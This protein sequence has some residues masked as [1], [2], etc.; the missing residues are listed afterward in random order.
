MSERRGCAFARVQVLVEV[1]A[2]GA[3]GQDC[4]LGQAAEQA[5]E[6]VVRQLVRALEKL[7]GNSRIIETKIV[8]VT[9][10]HQ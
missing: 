9:F 8:D 3:W 4:T 10:R 1:A 2:Q 7:P 6:D 5:E